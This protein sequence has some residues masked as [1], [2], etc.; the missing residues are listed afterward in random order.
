MKYSKFYELTEQL[1]KKLYE[2][3]DDS[4]S[5]DQW[6]TQMINLIDEISQFK[7]S[8]T[9][10]NKKTDSTSLDPT[11]WFSARNIAHQMLDSSIES[12]QSIKNQPAWQPVPIEI[13]DAIE[14]EAVPEQ[15]QELSHVYHD[16]I[17]HVLP[18]ARGN[19]HPRFWGWV[20]GEG[21]LGGVLADMMTATININAGGCTHSGVLVERTVIQWM[22]QLFGFPKDDNG[23]IVVTG[24]S[25][26]TVIS[27][28]TARRRLLTNVRQDG[29]VNGPHL[30]VYASTEAHMCV[31]KALELLGFGSKALHSISVDDNFCIKID[32]LKKT[33]ENDRNNGLIP[34]A[35]I[36]N[37][38]IN[39]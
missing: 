23:G 17:T 29:I 15:G 35:I 32:E 9:T 28:A 1:S 6:K 22:R 27:M 39:Y 11:N 26:A 3:V 24:T 18:Y 8:S 36:G 4:K 14:H 21:T 37:A 10:L 34:F 31:V 7:L 30:I 2:P 16:I 12:I 25:M 20:M 19:R 38:G 5:L 33:I 13:R